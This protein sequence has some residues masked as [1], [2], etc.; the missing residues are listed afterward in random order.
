[1][2]GVATLGLGLAI[3]TGAVLCGQP[4]NDTQSR[5]GIV[6]TLGDRIADCAS[7]GIDTPFGYLG[8]NPHAIEQFPQG[9]AVRTSIGSRF[10]LARKN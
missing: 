7:R 9:S 10:V 5:S 2:R 8:C 1:M 4:Q 3:M 6:L